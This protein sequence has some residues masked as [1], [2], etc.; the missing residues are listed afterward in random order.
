MH[1]FPHGSKEELESILTEGIAAL[2]P[3]LPKLCDHYAVRLFGS[4]AFEIETVC[5]SKCLSRRKMETACF[6]TSKRIL[7]LRF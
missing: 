3:E 1:G 6:T 5:S 2:R 7:I 4:R